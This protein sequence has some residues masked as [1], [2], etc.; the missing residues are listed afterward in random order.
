MSFTSSDSVDL[1]SSGSYA[2]L[3]DLQISQIATPGGLCKGN[4]N[5]VRVNITNSQMVAVKVKIPVILYVSQQGEQ[6]SSYV[7]YLDGGIGPNSNYGQP[8]WFN[9]VVI[10][11]TGKGVTLKAVVNPDQDIHE[12][13]YKNN[14]KII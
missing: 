12:S 10:P 6:P 2:L 7:G 14:T 11:Q 4:L 5:K 13:N 9:N 8:V 1:N 3:P